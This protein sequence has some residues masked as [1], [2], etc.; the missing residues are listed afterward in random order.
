M[1]E[2]RVHLRY[3]LY[4]C[5]FWYSAIA[6]AGIVSL[7]SVPPPISAVRAGHTAFLAQLIRGGAALN[8]TDVRAR[9]AAHYA[10]LL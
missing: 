8:A 10:V 3:R 5:I 7:R 9:T 4:T 6:Q 2:G 1:F